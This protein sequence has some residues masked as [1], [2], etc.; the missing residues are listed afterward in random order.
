MTADADPIPTP[1]T[2]PLTTSHRRTQLYPTGQPAVDEL[3][4]I[5]TRLA[6]S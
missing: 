4:R 6:A 3:C 1:S 2:S 5:L